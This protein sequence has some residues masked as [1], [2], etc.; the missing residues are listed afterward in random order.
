M[1][2]GLPP[3]LPAAAAAGSP[4]ASPISA[5]DETLSGG[6]GTPKELYPAR[7]S[8]RA[9]AR[10]ARLGIPRWTQQIRGVIGAAE[11]AEGALQKDGPPW[12]AMQGGTR[13]ARDQRVPPLLPIPE[14]FRKRADARRLARRRARLPE[15]PTESCRPP[16]DRIAAGDRR[17]TPMRSCQRVVL[18]LGRAAAAPPPGTAAAAAAA[19]PGPGAARWSQQQQLMLH[20]YPSQGG[21]GSSSGAQLRLYSESGSESGGGGGESGVGRFWR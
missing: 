3:P 21:G 1:P 5:R 9:H 8:W 7:G 18:L 12:Q 11:G 15:A 6:A 20:Q 10:G 2:E 4:A 16:S 14:G 19:R 13:N 17:V